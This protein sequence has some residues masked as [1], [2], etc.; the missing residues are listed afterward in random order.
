MFKVLVKNFNYWLQASTESYLDFNDWKK[1]EIDFDIN[2]SKT[3]IGLDLSRADDLT[4]V[5]F[6]HLN[7]DSQQ[8]YV[9]SHSFVATKGGL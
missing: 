6:I 4:A 5:S 1:N 2:G 8:Y 3:Y 7:E 9:T